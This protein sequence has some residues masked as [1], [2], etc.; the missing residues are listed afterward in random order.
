MLL[1]M[2]MK[3]GLKTTAD[4]TGSIPMKE[5][6]KK[7]RPSALAY[8]CSAAWGSAGAL[9]GRRRAVHVGVSG[10]CRLLTPFF[11]RVKM[12]GVD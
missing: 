5:D 9:R 4:E 11:A 12:V 6:L 8:R 2:P 7:R 1:S 10:A 3:G